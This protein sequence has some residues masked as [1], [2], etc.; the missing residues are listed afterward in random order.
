MPSIIKSTITMSTFVY[1]LRSLC[2]FALASLLFVIQPVSAQAPDSDVVS[3]LKQRDQ[4][5]KALIGEA[6]DFTD[7][8]Q[9][10]LQ[11]VI[12]GVI[13]FN[14]MGQDAL[15]E[16]WETLTSEQQAEFIKVF[17]EIVRERSLSNL[18]IY[19]LDVE[20]EKVSVEGAEARVQTKTTYKKQP[21]Q[22]EYA[23]GFRG[24]T[25]RVDDIILDGVSTMEGYARS[26]QTYIRKRGFDALMQNLKKR[27]DK[28]NATE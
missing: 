7:A 13:D 8:Q 6:E 23:M 2:I 28:M 9:E 21:M 14:Q 17:S 19:R 27:L 12:N 16:E 11:N 18:D 20:Y 25:W 24:N 10:K 3:L 5:I 22:V 26:F 4:E 15:G 1:K